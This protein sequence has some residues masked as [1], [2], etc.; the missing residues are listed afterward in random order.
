L[1]VKVRFVEKYKADNPDSVV[2]LDADKEVLAM[3][4]QIKEAGR[5]ALI[6]FFTRLADEAA[7]DS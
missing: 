3:K 1:S 4:E 5:K 6:R 7:R 2:S